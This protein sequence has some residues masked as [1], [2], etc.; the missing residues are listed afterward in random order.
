M[1]T[2]TPVRFF[3]IAYLCETDLDF[4]GSHIDTVEITETCFKQLLADQGGTAPIEYERHT[5][6]DNGVAQVCLTLDLD[7]LPHAE[8]LQTL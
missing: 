7:D 2:S 6:F 5:V 8:E 1:I 4:D 3:T